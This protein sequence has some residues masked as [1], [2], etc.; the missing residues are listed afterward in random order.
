MY[1][2]CIYKIRQKH[3]QKHKERLWKEARKKHQ[4][5]YE[6]EKDKMQKEVRERY[7]NLPEERKQKLLGYMKSCY[8][9]HK[10]VTVKSL[11]KILLILG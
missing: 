1:F 11:N 5:I 8:L 3:D 2:F 4:K 6:E 9:A 7:Q 10:K